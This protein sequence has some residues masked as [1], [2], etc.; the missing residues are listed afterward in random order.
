M[1]N[2]MDFSLTLHQN[3]LSIYLVLKKIRQLF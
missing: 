1:D 3:Y 2:L